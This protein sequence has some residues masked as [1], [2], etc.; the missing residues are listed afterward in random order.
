[1]KTI[2]INLHP[3]GEKK[4]QKFLSILRRYLPFVFL[5]FFGLIIINV[6]GFV[7]ARF[8]NVPYEKLKKEWR[9]LGPQVE[10]ILSLNKEIDSLSQEKAEYKSLF[11]EDLQF[12]RIFVDIQ[13]SLPQNIWFERIEFENSKINFVGYIVK[14]NEDYLLSLDKF[15]KGLKKRKYFSR[16]FPKDKINLKTSRKT[17]VSGVKVVKFE[18]EC[19]RK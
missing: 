15:I 17:R 5:A 18:I 11:K 12:S 9:N 19:G 6:I 10:E 13:T 1:M 3:L 16:I 7:F 14:L 8:Q 4:E 2:T